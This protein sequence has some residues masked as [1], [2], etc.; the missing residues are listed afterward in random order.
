MF[1][2]VLITGGCGFVGSNLAMLLKRDFPTLKI[3][4]FDNLSKK[5]SELNVQRLTNAGILFI[6]GD[7]R[8]RNQLEAVGAFNLL[9]DTAAESSVLSGIDSSPDYVIETNLNGTLHCLHLAVKFNAKFIFLSTSRIYGIEALN[10]IPFEESVSRFTWAVGK[11]ASGINESFPI[12]GSRSFYGT[13]KLSW[14]YFIEEY[15]AFYGL[16]SI[17]NRC[18]LLA[19]AGRMGKVDQGVIAL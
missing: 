4:A 2:R 5:G 9:L 17:F 8:Y 19:G 16:K 12:S 10:K 15:A 3:I 18:G 7:V 13:S 1:Y 11:Y 14:E 6:L